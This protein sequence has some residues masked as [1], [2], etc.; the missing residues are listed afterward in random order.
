MEQ[1]FW[2]FCG[3][4]C[5]VGGSFF[6]WHRL[7]VQVETGAFT[8]VEIRQFA[9]RQALWIFT[10][11]IILWLLQT[12]IS[13]GA[14]PEFLRW[15]YPQRMAAMAVVILCWGALLYWIFLRNGAETLSKYAGALS[16]SPRFWQTPTAFKLLA[17]MVVA[18]GVFAILGNSR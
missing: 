6:T 4:W 9:A 17:I 7:K 8:R 10:P 18:S 2:V 5:G 3:L 11:C 12:T 15:P 14:G 16:S 13:G 1:F